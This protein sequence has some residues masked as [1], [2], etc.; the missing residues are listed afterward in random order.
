M[1]SD[2]IVLEFFKY[3]RTY[4][5]ALQFFFE[6]QQMIL[7]F[8]TIIFS[9]STHSIVFTVNFAGDILLANACWCI[10]NAANLSATS[11]CSSGA[12]RSCVTSLQHCI[13]R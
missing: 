4:F 1:F 2:T 5:E 7:T 6:I 8:L 11:G 9:Q 10:C 13:N 3:F 12:N